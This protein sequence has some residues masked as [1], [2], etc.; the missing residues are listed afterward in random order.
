MTKVLYREATKNAFTSLDKQLA[1]P[2]HIK[3]LLQVVSELKNSKTLLNVIEKYNYKFTK[4]RFE[5]MIDK[6]LKC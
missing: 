4:S 2:Q 3:K 5:N 6:S 1:L